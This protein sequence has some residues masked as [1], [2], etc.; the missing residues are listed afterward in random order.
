MLFDL[1]TGEAVHRW[2][3]PGSPRV[4]CPLLVNRPDGVKVILTT[5]DEGM[6]NDVRAASPAAG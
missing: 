1:E 6:S 2:V 4:T 3:T 5:A